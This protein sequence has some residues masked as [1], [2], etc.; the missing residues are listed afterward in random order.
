MGG[1]KERS[2]A[3]AIPGQEQGS[4]KLIVDGKGELTIEFMDTV[5]TFFLIQMDNDFCVGIC[6]KVMATADK[7]LSKFRVIEYFT[8]KD[9]PLVFIL[10]VD[11]VLASFKVDNG[12]AGVCESNTPVLEKTKSI[13]PAMA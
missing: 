3:H 10:V 2:D 6:G 9:N 13:R 5:C 12:Q 8:V 4:V 7:L 1:V 11:S